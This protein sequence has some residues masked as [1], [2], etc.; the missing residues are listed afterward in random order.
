[1]YTDIKPITNTLGDNFGSGASFRYFPKEWATQPIG[2]FIDPTTGQVAPEYFQTLAFPPS[3]IF[4][5]D[6]LLESIYYEEKP[7]SA[8]GGDYFDCMLTATLLRDDA[9]RMLNLN[10]MR[11]HQYII[12]YSG[13]NYPDNT[14]KVIGDK[15]RGMRFTDD[16]ES[17]KTFSDS[18]MF[19]I[20]FSLSCQ[21][22]PP[23]TVIALP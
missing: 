23:V 5:A 2:R 20:Q 12:L 16:F 19:N 14:W 17:G 15:N 10:N 18:A 3:D 9:S 22:R 13:Q 7:K 6:T 21:D 4:K 11:Y 8:D 1:M